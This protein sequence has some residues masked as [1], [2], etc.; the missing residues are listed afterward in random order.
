MRFN[1]HLDC[2]ENILVH[3][4][5]VFSESCVLFTGP[6]NIFFTKNNFKTGSYGIIHTFKN[7]FYYK[8]FQFSTINGI[9]IEQ[10]A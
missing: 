7:Y 2:I 3:V 1:L 9:Q 6:V 10:Y 4:V 5:G 8:Y